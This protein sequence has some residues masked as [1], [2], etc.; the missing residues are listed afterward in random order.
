VLIHAFFF[1]RYQEEMK[2]QE[3]ESC[4]KLK[5]EAKLMQAEVSSNVLK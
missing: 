3:W 5:L 4:K 2:I 1:V